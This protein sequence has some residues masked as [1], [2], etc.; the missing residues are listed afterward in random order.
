MSAFA[1]GMDELALEV[2]SLSRFT[3]LSDVYEV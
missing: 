3:K 1:E 2:D